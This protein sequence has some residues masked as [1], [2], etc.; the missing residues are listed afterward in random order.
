[1]SRVFIN[2]EDGRSMVPMNG[3]VLVREFKPETNVV[4]AGGI[5]LPDRRLVGELARAEVMATGDSSSVLP[6]D[7][8]FYAKH[9]GS[10]VESVDHELYLLV[11]EKEIM[12][13]RSRSTE[14]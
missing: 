13:R 3:H 9:V 4:S 14:T 5:Y 2:E 1:M 10:E 12:A 8:I 6:G 7:V 11:P